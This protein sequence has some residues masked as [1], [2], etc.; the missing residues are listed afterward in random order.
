MNLIH[1]RSELLTQFLSAALGID[2]TCGVTTEG[3]NIF[4]HA[5]HEHYSGQRVHPG[6]LSYSPLATGSPILPFPCCLYV[7]YSR[8][9]CNYIHCLGNWLPP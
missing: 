4:E 2:I 5:G 7:D 6:G 3:F 1:K 9:S 8:E